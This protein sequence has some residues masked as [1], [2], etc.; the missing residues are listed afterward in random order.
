[1]LHQSETDENPRSEETGGNEIWSETR[2]TA[3]FVSRS[4]GR[5]RDELILGAGGK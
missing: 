5:G 2:G 4:L 3:D 1:M